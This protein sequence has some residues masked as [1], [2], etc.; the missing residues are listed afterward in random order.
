MGFPGQAWR[1]SIM[2]KVWHGGTHATRYYRERLDNAIQPGMRI[3][4]AGSGWDKKQVSIKYK[5]TCTVVGIDLDPAVA[6]RF[7]SEF[8]LA[9]LNKMPFEDNSFDVVFSEYVFEHLEEPDGAFQE[10]RRVLKPGGKLLVITPNLFS[11]K[12]LAAHFTPY[13]FHVWMGNIRYGRGHEADMYPTTFLC[14][15]RGAFKRFAKKHG[16][17]INNMA[18]VTNGPTWFSKFPVI[19]EIFQLFHLLIDR[20]EALS[21]LRCGMIVEMEKQADPCL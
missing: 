5:D 17:Q 7:H 16:F 11:Y 12:S 1:N 10:I 6:E 21:W 20:I 8:H 13:S 14:N 19:F 9:S 18:I 15:T 2:E 3:L 4:H